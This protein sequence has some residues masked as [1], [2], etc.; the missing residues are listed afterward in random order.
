MV[1]TTFKISHVY[2]DDDSDKADAS[3]IAIPRLFTSKKKSTELKM[4][5]TLYL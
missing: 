4:R 1:V 2:N 5:V 3:V